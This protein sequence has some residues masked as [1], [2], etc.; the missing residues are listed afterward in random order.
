MRP[1]QYSGIDPV[2]ARDLAAALDVAAAGLEADGA[3]IIALLDR[4]DGDTSGLSRF[5]HDADWCAEAAE[6]V[7]YRACLIEND[8]ETVAALATITE[9]DHWFEPHM[10]DTIETGKAFFRLGSIAAGIEA[11]VLAAQGQ[12]IAPVGHLDRI[13][14]KIDYWSDHLDRHPMSRRGSA[15]LQ[16]FQG[17]LTQYKTTPWFYQQQLHDLWRRIPL[18]RNLADNRFLNFPLTGAPGQ[19]L[20][21]RTLVPLGIV[22]GAYDI[23]A[24]REG[25]AS[26]DPRAIS[27]LAA[28]TAQ[29]IGTF[30]VAGVGFVPVVGWAIL[31]AVALY[32]LGTWIVDNWDDIV[33]WVGDVGE[34]VLDTGGD[35]W[36]WVRGRYDEDIVAPGRP[37]DYYPDGPPPVDEPIVV[38]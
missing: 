6:D 34:W 15:R 27:D 18:A 28:G 4:W 32:H 38:A 19:G 8:A 1:D 11:A 13:N 31:G 3:R 10:V 12:Q 9:L 20:L 2:A 35:I 17:A 30:S 25:F 23:F 16:H 37:D 29:I 7:R 22:T 24:N 21:N 26:G 33:T 5:S 36:D 14:R